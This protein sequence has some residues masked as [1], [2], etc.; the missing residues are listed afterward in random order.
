MPEGDVLAISLPRRGSNSPPAYA[1]R[2]AIRQRFA[3]A[4][5]IDTSTR[6]P[7]PDACRCHSAAIT[8]NAACMPVPESPMVG[9]GLSGGEPGKP[10]THMAPP[11]ACA[12]MSNAL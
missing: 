3:T 2:I 7:T 10:V 1:S 8:P 9:P 5:C 6:W 12:I 4:S 11:V